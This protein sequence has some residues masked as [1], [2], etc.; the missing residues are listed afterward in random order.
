MQKARYRVPEYHLPLVFWLSVVLGIINLFV[1]V[2]VCDF[3]GIP[4]AGTIPMSPFWGSLLGFFLGI[5]GLASV[6]LGGDG[7]GDI[8]LTLGGEASLYP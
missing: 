2:I 7:L 4:S 8:L 5:S 6:S 1:A 3:G